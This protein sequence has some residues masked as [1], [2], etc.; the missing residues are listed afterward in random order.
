MLVSSRSLEEYAA[1][2]ALDDA[3]LSGG[4]L[5][6]AAGASEFAARAAQRGARVVAVDPAYRL[7]DAG[8]LQRARADGRRGAAIVDEF[9][10]RFTWAAWYGDRDRRDALRSAALETFTADF[11]RGPGRYVAAAVPRLPFRDRSFGLAVCSHL[12][13]AWA[14]TFDV[15]WHRTAVLELTRVAAEV[16]I[17]PTVRQGD[18]EAVPFMA[19]LLASLGT[20][21]ITT[22]FQRVAYE[23]QRGAN[24]M[25]VATAG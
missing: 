5:D 16:R 25:L 8:L 13:F 24:Q 1:M 11:R 10:D 15:S 12:L 23:F 17:F 9:P 3:D 22:R 6:C 20:D 7:D 18:G 14:D 4:V 21:G 19:E 2:F